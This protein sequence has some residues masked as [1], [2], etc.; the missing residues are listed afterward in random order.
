MAGNAVVGSLR[1]SLGL[2]SAQFTSGMKTAQTGLQRFAGV[3]KA[4]ALAIA[5]AMAAAGGA[6]ATAMAGVITRAGDMYELSQALGVTVEDLSR[7][8]YAAELSGVQIEGLEKA[9]KKLSVSLFDASQ[10]GTGPAA[11][12]FRMLGISAVDAEGNV[13]PV[14]DVMGDLADRFSKMPGGAEKTALA[15][16]VFGKAGADMIPMLNEGRDGLQQMYDEAQRLGI[17]LDTETAAS[18]EALGDELTRLNAAKDGV[19]TKITTGMLPALRSLAGALIKTSQDSRTMAVIG[20]ALGWTLRALVTV[21]VLV[22]AAFIGVARDIGTAA[23]AAYK[24]VQQDF[25]GAAV[26]AARG[27][28]ETQAYLKGV[29]Q[30]VADLWTPAGP[31]PAI[32]AATEAVVDL[33]DATGRAGRAA[34]GLT[35]DQ[36]ALQAV[37]EAGRQTYEQTRTPAEIY[38]ARVSELRH[39]LDLAAISQDTF[40]RAMIDARKAFE[41]SDPSTQMWKDTA[42]AIRD[43]AGAAREDAAKRV[44]DGLENFRD[45]QEDAYDATYDGVRGGLQAAADGNLGQYLAQRIRDA[46]FDNLATTLTDL[47]RG[48]RGGGGGGGLSGWAS[49]A[50][51]IL[52]SFAGG[53]PGFA[54][55]G[56]FKVGGQAGVDK[57]LVSFRA[58]KGEMVDI[59]RPGQDRGS[60]GSP[61]HFDLRGAVMT[62]DLLRQMEGMTAKGAHVSVQTSRAVVP[63]DD[64]RRRRFSLT[65]A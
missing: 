28:G 20:Q 9:I 63:A 47:I 53:I 23:V 33:A 17:V 5:G 50:G 18:A 65:G 6:I 15:I 35:D 4:G 37:M 54:T 32:T 42:E 57:N 49:A 21:A 59:R 44:A 45:L 62:S 43:A 26:S 22:G 60:S 14:I 56:S 39:Q 61:I 51:S 1:I 19:I 12:A 16:R 24:W 27:F 40:N 13:R 36:R 25:A 58:T 7:M 34:R 41:A 29:E 10:S 2:D 55:G 8:T 38:A 64:A 30:F 52:K 31:P 46:L 48:P 11:N 3:A